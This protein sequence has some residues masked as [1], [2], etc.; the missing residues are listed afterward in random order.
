[1]LGQNEGSIAD[2]HNKGIDVIEALT[3]IISRP[4]EMMVIRPWHG[5]QY[6]S[7]AVVFLSTM[8]VIFMPVV[9]AFANAVTRF[10][11]GTPPISPTGIFN[12]G[13]FAKLYLLMSV[14]HGC[15]LWRRMIHL[16]LEQLSRFEGPPLP[17]FRLLPGSGSS[18]GTR[19]LWEPIAVFFVA[20]SLERFQII[21]SGLAFY[22]KMAALCLGMRQYIAWLRAWQFLRDLL[23]AKFAGPIIARLVEGTAT[24]EDLA[25]IHMASFPEN[26]PPEIRRDAA[27]HIARVISPEGK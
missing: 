17:F 27:L 3:G 4:V 8:L 1:M 24:S 15:R 23:D 13:S 19:I 7:V 20:A 9:S 14:F 6:Y 12:F 10:I 22:L 2:L 25:A 18:W 21:E 26:L 16:H 5:T 11:P